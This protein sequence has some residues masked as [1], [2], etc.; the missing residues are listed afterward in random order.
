M[1]QEE[2]DKILEAARVTGLT[3][4]TNGGEFPARNQ[5]TDNDRTTF[6]TL[7]ENLKQLNNEETLGLEQRLIIAHGI[8]AL[9]HYI[10]SITPSPYS[11]P[12]PPPARRSSA[13]G[14]RKKNKTKKKSNKSK[15]KSKKRRKSKSKKRRKSKSK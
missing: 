5:C 13:G 8:V 9:T 7:K 11:P 12:H 1:N 4:L 10:E 14:G 15:K 3:H 6:T 2:K